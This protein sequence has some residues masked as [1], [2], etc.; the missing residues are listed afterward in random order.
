MISFSN[1]LLSISFDQLLP[2]Q[3]LA[4]YNMLLTVVVKSVV[5]C[6]IRQHINDWL[7]LVANAACAEK[8]DHIRHDAVSAVCVAASSIVT[9]AQSK[10]TVDDGWNVLAL[11]SGFVIY[12]PEFL[13]TVTYMH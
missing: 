4:E 2:L 1:V 9:V 7:A 12:N 13:I 8:P 11:R 3:M 6:G 10:C 5:V